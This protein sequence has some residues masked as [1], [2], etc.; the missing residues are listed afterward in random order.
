MTDWL[1]KARAVKPYYQKG[2]QT[3][4]N[5]EALKVKGIYEQWKNLIGVKVKKGYIFAYGNDLYRTEQPD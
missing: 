1:G 5:Q 3:L 2:A 4:S